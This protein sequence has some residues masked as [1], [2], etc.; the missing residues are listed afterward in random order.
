MEKACCKIVKSPCTRILELCG[1]GVSSSRF[2]GLGVS[3][4]RL[5]GIRD[6]MVLSSRAHFCPVGKRQ[7]RETLNSKSRS[8]QNQKP[9]S[10]DWHSEAPKT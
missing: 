8:L 9:K 1:V 2:R 5:F 4:F 6:S 10:Q 3:G 7:E